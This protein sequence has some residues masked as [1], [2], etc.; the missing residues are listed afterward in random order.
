MQYLYMNLNLNY[1]NKRLLDQVKS[2]DFYRRVFFQE[3]DML[4]SLLNFTY[5]VVI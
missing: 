4:F 2:R 1:F 5:P 3:T